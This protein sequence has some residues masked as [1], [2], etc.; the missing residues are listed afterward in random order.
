[1]YI[2]VKMTS[3]RETVMFSFMYHLGEAIKPS[4]DA[5]AKMLLPVMRAL[6]ALGLYV[7]IPKEAMLIPTDTT[8]I[9][10]N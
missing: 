7:L 2:G 9:A 6:Y 4:S 3:G 5:L 1:M 8:I 10:L